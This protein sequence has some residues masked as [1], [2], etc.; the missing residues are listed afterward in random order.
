MSMILASSLKMH[1]ASI[2]GFLRKFAN[3]GELCS[4]S[5]VCTQGFLHAG[6]GYYVYN[7]REG[8]FLK[9]SSGARLWDQLRSPIMGFHRTTHNSHIQYP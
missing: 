8:P 2:Q 1:P 4:G 6:G 3:S 7:I 5:T 9:P